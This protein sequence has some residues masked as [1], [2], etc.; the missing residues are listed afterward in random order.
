MSLVKMTRRPK[1]ALE[2]LTKKKKPRNKEEC[3]A[4]LE[5]EPDSHNETIHMPTQSQAMMDNSQAELP[6]EE[7]LS[8]LSS[9]GLDLLSSELTCSAKTHDMDVQDVE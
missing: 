7:E 1:N 5:H 8:L 9:E 3:S 4:L 6:Q 2:K